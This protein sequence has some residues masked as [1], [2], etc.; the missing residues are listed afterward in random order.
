MQACTT[1]PR[2]VRQNKRQCDFI[3][4]E[5]KYPAIQEQLAG[6]CIA[7]GTEIGERP[8]SQGSCNVVCLVLVPRE[9]LEG[10]HDR[11]KFEAG[12]RRVVRTPLILVRTWVRSSPGN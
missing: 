3:F 12:G 2:K 9:G 4:K 7:N 1:N 10:D 11:A 8:V 5:T 6:R